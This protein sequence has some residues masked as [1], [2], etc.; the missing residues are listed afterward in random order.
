MILKNRLNSWCARLVAAAALA[1]TAAGDGR[2]GTIVIDD[3][4]SPNAADVY[5]IGL[6]DSAPAQFTTIAPGVVGD[7]RE[8]TIEILG[9]A[10]SISALGMIG[11]DFFV[12]GS[13]SPAAKATLVYDGIGSAGLGI[14]LSDGGINTGFVLEFNALDTGPDAPQMDVEIRL[15]GPGGTAVYNGMIDHNPNTFEETV[16]FSAFNLTGTFSFSNVDR[17]TYVFNASAK[18]GVDFEISL[19]TV[20]IPIPEPASSTLAVAG[21]GLVLAHCWRRRRR[22]VPK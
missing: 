3:F 2:A 22:S 12:F 16:L 5:V 4:L 21:A 18:S 14:D 17:I 10:R 7:E 11:N 6:F 15:E 13:S 8:V 1:W 19:L 20:G 9:T